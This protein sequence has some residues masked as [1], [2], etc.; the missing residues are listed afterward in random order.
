V[1]QDVAKVVN[2]ALTIVF[3]VV[4]VWLGAFIFRNIFVG[5]MVNKF[6]AMSKRVK[7]QNEMAAVGSATRFA[8]ISNSS[9]TN[10]LVS[11]LFAFAIISKLCLIG[12]CF[13][14]TA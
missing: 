12:F 4:W 1:Q 6:D 7:R 9:C 10:G 5:V 14:S 3:F 11:F 8:L 13:I 2:P